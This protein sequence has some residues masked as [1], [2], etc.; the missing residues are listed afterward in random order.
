MDVVPTAWLASGQPSPDGLPMPLSGQCARCGAGGP[1]WSTAY[2]V[3]K[4]FTGWDGWR[5]PAGSGL[6][7]ACA[8]AYRDSALRS[9][10]LHIT[11]APSVKSLSSPALLELLKHP[12]TADTALAVPLRRGRK[13]VLPSAAWGRICVDDTTI[14][15]SAADRERLI[16]FCRLRRRGFTVEMI[17]REAP[18]YRQVATLTASAL[19]SVMSDWTA[20]AGW[21]HRS[22]WFNLAAIATQ[23][24]ER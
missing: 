22:P 17:R 12:V 13:H 8:W 18:P 16:A 24:V 7:Q 10:V 5:D 14:S 2:V 19:K 3:S 11:R 1:I 20:V 6:C 21:R 9:H 4:N 15:W 23:E